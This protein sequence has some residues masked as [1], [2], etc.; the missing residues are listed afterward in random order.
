MIQAWSS[1]WIRIF[2]EFEV[3]ITTKDIEVKISLVRELNRGGLISQE[4]SSNT[5]VGVVRTLGKSSLEVVVSTKGNVG[6]GT[7]FGKGSATV[8]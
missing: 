2:K 5:V 6:I 4:S 1:S 7:C 8:R 3:N